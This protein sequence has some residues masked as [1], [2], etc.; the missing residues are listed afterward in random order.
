MLNGPSCGR[1]AFGEVV[2]DDPETYGSQR[3]ATRQAART[4]ASVYRR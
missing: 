3:R 2:N 1:W 4:A